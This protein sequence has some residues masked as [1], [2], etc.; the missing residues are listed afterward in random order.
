MATLTPIFRFFDSGKVIE[1][2]LNRLE[3]KIDREGDPA[4]LQACI[5]ISPGD[6]VLRLQSTIAQGRILIN[7]K[8][9]KSITMDVK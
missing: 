5:Q 3:F 7:L 2:Y 1:F 4:N 9:L 6:I 8:G